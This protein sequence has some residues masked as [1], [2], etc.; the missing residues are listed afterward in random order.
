ML[1]KETFALASRGYVRSRIRVSMEERKKEKGRELQ[2][3]CRVSMIGAGRAYLVPKVT[4]V[5][6]GR[7]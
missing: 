1:G 4:V 2:M 5:L 3:V 6:E 7:D